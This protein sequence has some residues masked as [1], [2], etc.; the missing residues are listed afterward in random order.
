VDAIVSQLV[1]LDHEQPEAGPAGGSTEAYP[2]LEL[3]Q[4]T[5]PPQSEPAT[6]TDSALSAQPQSP[7]P[8]DEQSDIIVTGRRPSPEDPLEDLNSS[9][10]KVTQAVDES[11]VAPIAFAYEDIMPRPVRKGLSNFLHNLGEPI[12]FLNFLLQLKPGKA[13]ETLGRFA[14][15]T[16]LGAGGLVDVAKRKPFNLPRR[17]NGF[18]NTLG[19]YGVKQGPYFF[20]PLV[21]P[22]TLRDFIGGR[23]DLLLL[24]L[25]LPKWS[26]KPEVVVPIWVLKELDRRIEFE[27]ELS[28]IRVTQDPYVTA[29]TRYLEHRQAEID[30]LRGREPST[31][32]PIVPAPSPTPVPDR[33]QDQ[34]PRDPGG[35]SSIDLLGRLPIVATGAFTR[36]AGDFKDSPVVSLGDEPSE[37]IAAPALAFSF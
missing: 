27:D 18:A 16:T 28:Q 32:K 21:G 33:S 4:S 10:F 34:T 36:L 8:T 23:L 19:Y 22:T 25:V 6:S 2:P 11:F 13:A 5:A 9:S 7:A 17:E 15:N 29:R 3:A 30:E 12:V 26:R 14:I 24:P 37:W 20:L 31:I 35:I 1:A